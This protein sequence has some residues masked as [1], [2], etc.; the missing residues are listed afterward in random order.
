MSTQDGNQWNAPENK[1][2]GKG[3]DP[4]LPGEGGEDLIRKG[5]RQEDQLD[6]LKPGPEDEK[7]PT[8]AG[9][10]PAGHVDQGNE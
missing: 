6:T 7:A 5:A 9:S 2:K 3:S 4:K 8:Q 1:P 10:P